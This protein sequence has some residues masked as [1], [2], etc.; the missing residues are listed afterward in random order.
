MY[1]LLSHL[2]GRPAEYYPF[3]AEKVI[4]QDER[5]LTGTCVDI[6]Q[7]CGKQVRMFYPNSQR[8]MVKWMGINEQMA[9]KFV[10]A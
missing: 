8:H 2:H 7:Q 4:Q 1:G 10:G 3:E 5:T 9:N 6:R